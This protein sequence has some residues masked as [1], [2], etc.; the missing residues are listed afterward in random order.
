MWAFLWGWMRWEWRLLGLCALA[1]TAAV[2]YAQFDEEFGDTLTTCYSSLALFLEH[3]ERITD[4]EAV[5]R[6]AVPVQEKLVA[7]FPRPASRRTLGLLYD[8]LAILEY[9]KAE[10]AKRPT[11]EAEAVWRKALAVQA[12]HLQRPE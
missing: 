8:R 2:A 6:E 5:L 7:E 12:L 11:T 3:R 9:L 1:F 4:A 10:A